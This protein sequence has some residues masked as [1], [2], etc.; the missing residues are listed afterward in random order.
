METQFLRLLVDQFGKFQK[1]SSWFDPENPLMDV[2]NDSERVTHINHHQ[3]RLGWSE[4]TICFN[5]I[6][7]FIDL[8]PDRKSLKWYFLGLKITSI[9][10]WW[11]SQSWW[12]DI[13]MCGIY[14]GRIYID[15]VGSFLFSTSKGSILGWC[16]IFKNHEV[17]F[18]LVIS[19][20]WNSIWWPNV[21]GT[22]F[23]CP[24]IKLK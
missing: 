5:L 24:F 20:L 11:P 21:R 1:I 8:K 19:F 10:S 14:R 4:H 17:T 13:F 3:H 23:I 12:L 15:S 18:K 16:E 6:D 7:S 9:W 22:F 2:R